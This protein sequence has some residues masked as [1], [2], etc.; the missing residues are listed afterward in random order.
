[1]HIKYK[2]II[3]FCLLVCILARIL[4]DL[5]NVFLNSSTA[6]WSNKHENDIT[7]TESRGDES[8]RNC[9]QICSD[10]FVRS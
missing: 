3:L 7:A 4:D 5:A 8:K 1:V 6:G 9:F 2:H 10:G